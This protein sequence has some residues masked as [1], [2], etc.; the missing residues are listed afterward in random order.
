[1]CKKNEIMG[2]TAAPKLEQPTGEHREPQLT[3]AEPSEKEGLAGQLE[4]RSC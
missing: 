1:M 3:G 4:G 2:P